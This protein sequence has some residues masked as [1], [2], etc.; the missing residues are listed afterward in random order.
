M[1]EAVADEVADVRASDRLTESAV[2]LVASDKE[3]DRQ[4][5][6]LL[7]AA[8]RLDSAAKPILEVNPRHAVVTALTGVE[9]SALRG[10]VV[11]LLLGTAR[12]L[13]GESPADA[14]AFAEKLNRLIMRSFGDGCLRARA[15]EVGS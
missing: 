2:C 1:K 8:G 7:N 9:D 15:H 4:F 5:G 12:V 11:Y 14:N 10:D 3:P 6:R 13:D